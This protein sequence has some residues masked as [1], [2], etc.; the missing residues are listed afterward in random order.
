[1]DFYADPSSDLC[2]EVARFDE[3]RQAFQRLFSRLEPP[4]GGV[5][6]L[7]FAP[8]RH[9]LQVTFLDRVVS[10]PA[11]MEVEVNDGKVTPVR[12]TLTEAGARSVITRDDARA[13]REY[14]AYGRRTKINSEEAVLYEISAIAAAPVAY[15]PKERMPY[16]R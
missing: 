10:K 12:V 11:E 6:R 9:R 5:L 1:V 7:A 13:R 2:W 14:G 8:G 16:T 3:Q 4:Q 15:Q